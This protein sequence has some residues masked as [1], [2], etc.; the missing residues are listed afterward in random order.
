MRLIFEM[1]PKRVSASPKRKAKPQSK[2][3][4]E[5]KLPKPQA[6]LHELEQKITQLE[7]ELESAA[8]VNKLLTK[9]RERVTDLLVVADD[10][11]E[12]LNKLIDDNNRPIET[13]IEQC[14]HC[15][16]YELL[17]K[18]Y[19]DREKDKFYCRWCHDEEAES[20]SE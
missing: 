3:P 7:T 8:A 9:Q 2:S 17:S 20:S 1:P 14:S 5:S 12:H 11:V 19:V 18:G 15:E 16:V 13:E 6:K 4:L 10:K